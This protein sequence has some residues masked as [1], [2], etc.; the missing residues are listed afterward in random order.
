LHDP[1]LEPGRH[2][3]APLDLVD[4]PVEMGV[5]CEEAAD[6][7]DADRVQ[8]VG[9]VR[10][11][12]PVRI[13]ALDVHDRVAERLDGVDLVAHVRLPLG[14]RAAALHADGGAAALERRRWP[15]I[16]RLDSQYPAWYRKYVVMIGIDPGS[17]VRLWQKIFW[18]WA[19]MAPGPPPAEYRLK[20]CASG[21]AAS[22]ESSATL[23]ARLLLWR[24]LRCILPVPNLAP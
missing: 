1:L 24:S 6:A 19:K 12:V 23:G 18:T 17:A 3:L 14:Q 20:R 2:L 8:H 15:M 16:S 9:G 13:A 7:A 22:F 11:A 4:G 10:G 21:S 5:V